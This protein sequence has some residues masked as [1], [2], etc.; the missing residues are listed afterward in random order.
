MSF[1]FS[2][3]SNKQNDYY[4]GVVLR[5]ISYESGYTSE[6]AHEL[7]RKA[8]LKSDEVSMGNIHNEVPRSTTELS[9]NEFN[10]YIEKIKQFATEF[11]SLVIPDPR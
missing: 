8:F 5:L 4:W 7:F 6:Q 2:R 1:T 11:Y 10:E 3:R 9:T